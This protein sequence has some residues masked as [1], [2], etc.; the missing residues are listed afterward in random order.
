MWPVANFFSPPLVGYCFR[1]YF[2]LF[3]LVVYLFVLKSI[4]NNADNS[5]RVLI[6]SLIP[7]PVLS[8]T[9]W[10]QEE[11]LPAV[12]IYVGLIAWLRNSRTAA[13]AAWSLGVVA[14]KVFVWPL[15]TLGLVD[16]LRTK[17][18][19]DFVMTLTILAMGYMGR[20]AGG[21]SGF[22]G[23][24]PTNDF[25]NSL[26]S[27]PIAEHVFTLKLQYYLSL[28]LCALWGGLCVAYWVLARARIQIV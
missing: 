6:I 4:P 25:T 12:F 16:S 9:I 10:G 8:D 14:G 22:E 19:R 17:K 18:Y 23:F 1:L 11:I 3:E 15:L 13:I 2:S 28:V 27:M 26:W 24:V 7:F 5:L 21:S 20:I